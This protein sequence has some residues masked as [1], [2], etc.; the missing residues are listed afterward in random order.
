MKRMTTIAWVV[1]WA[2]ALSSFPQAGGAESKKVTLQHWEA[3]PW[4]VFQKATYCAQTQVLWI[5]FRSGH[6]YV[7]HSVLP[8]TFAAFL[9]VRGKAAFFNQ[10]IRRNHACARVDEP[11]KSL[12]AEV[13]VPRP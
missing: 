9:R 10:K 3:P 8:R 13:S 12:P 6:E 1:M 7:Y 2:V 11:F 5:R 4:S